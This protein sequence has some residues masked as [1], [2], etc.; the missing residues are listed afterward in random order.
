MSH[1]TGITLRLTPAGHALRAE[2]RP[3][4]GQTQWPLYEVQ[5]PVRCRNRHLPVSGRPAPGPLVSVQHLQD[6]ARGAACQLRQSG[7]LPVPPTTRPMHQA[8]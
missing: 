7:G 3:E 8:N 1:R 4:P 6:P 2:A 5:V